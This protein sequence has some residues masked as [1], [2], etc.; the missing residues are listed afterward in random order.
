[1]R[2][3]TTSVTTISA[4]T[5]VSFSVTLASVASVTAIPTITINTA[6]SNIGMTR[7]MAYIISVSI[8]NAAI[9]GFG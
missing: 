8:S 7:W 5:I 6:L 2:S 1:M 9:V 3:Y 4:I